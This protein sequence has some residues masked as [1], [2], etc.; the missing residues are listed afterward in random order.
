MRTSLKRRGRLQ[1]GGPLRK[2]RR[3]RK[4]RIAMSTLDALWSLRVRERDNATCQMVSPECAGKLESAHMYSKQA[5]PAIRWDVG[6]GNAL[7]SKH[8]FFVHANPVQAGRFY[9]ERWGRTHLDTLWIKARAIAKID[10]Y[11]VKAEL[12]APRWE[13]EGR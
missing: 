7:C 3:T 1:S 2:R 12:R 8:H 4:G 5:Y 10:R 9:E 13:V 11:A 6:N